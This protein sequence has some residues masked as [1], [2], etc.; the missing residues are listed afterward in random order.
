MHGVSGKDY[1]VSSHYVS[2]EFSQG[3]DQVSGYVFNDCFMLV[4]TSQLFSLSVFQ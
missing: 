1:S 3:F 4:S 2:H